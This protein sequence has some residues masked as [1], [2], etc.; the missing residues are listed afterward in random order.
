MLPGLDGWSFIRKF[1]ENSKIPVLFLTACDAIEDRVKGLE[2]G[3][4]DYLVKPFSYAELLARVRTLLRR[5]PLREPEVLQIADLEVD[6]LKRRATRGGRRIDLTTIVK[7]CG[8]CRAFKKS[9]LIHTQLLNSCQSFVNQL[10]RHK[11]RSRK[12]FIIGR[13]CKVQ[14]EDSLK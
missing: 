10:W 5:T 9:V 8:F 13:E 1:R 11:H 14:H 6:M 3:A 2:L 12:S 4:D 7:A